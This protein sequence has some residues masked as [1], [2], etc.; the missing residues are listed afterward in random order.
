V[1]FPYASKYES[2]AAYREFRRLSRAAKAAWRE[3]HGEPVHIGSAYREYARAAGIPVD[4]FLASHR[5][6]PQNRAGG[7]PPAVCP[8]CGAA[9]EAEILPGCRRANPEGY[10]LV[11]VCA[12]EECL[13]HVFVLDGLIDAAN[14]LEAGDWAGLSKKEGRV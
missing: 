12:G 4:F 10:S 2:S 14:K 9:L 1:T 5:E 8:K 3:K 13:Y 7:L 6:R 11:M